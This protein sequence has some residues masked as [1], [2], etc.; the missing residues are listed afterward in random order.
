MAVQNRKLL[1]VFRQKQGMALLAYI[2]LAVIIVSLISLIGAIT[3]V[4]K[5]R[6]M[7]KFLPLLVSFSAGGMLGAAFLDLLPAAI[8][9]Q[10]PGTFPLV[11]AGIALFYILEKTFLW[12]HQHHVAIK[13]RGHRH[14][15]RG[16]HRAH[17]QRH[18]QSYAYMNLIG[19]GI[20]NFLDGMIIAT[21]FVVSVPLGIVVSLAVV[22]HEIPQ[23]LGDF[24]VLIFGGFKV[25]TALMF[26]MLSAV[27]AILGA[28]VGYFFSTAVAGFTG[29]L[30]PFAVG[31]FL[32]I[33]LVDLL[34]E[35]RKRVAVERTISQILAFLIGIGL[36]WLVNTLIHNYFGIA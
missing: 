15:K 21:S 31:G 18:V 28:L 36:I 7:R 27:T 16:E 23:E 4:I 32:Y 17:Y 35:L 2:L 19:D 26:N 5:E 14:R 1:N 34:P 30:L 29:M 9:A 25:G 33:A 3:L 13:H 20:H 8:E 22:L 6:Q 24:S 11:I 12:Y 10:V